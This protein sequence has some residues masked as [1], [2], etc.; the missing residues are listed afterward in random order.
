[1]KGYKN[2]QSYSV[3]IVDIKRLTDSP[4]IGFG[5]CAKISV[6]Q[7]KQ[8]IVKLTLDKL[9]L[10]PIALPY[11]FQH[12][13]YRTVLKLISIDLNRIMNDLG[14]QVQL[15]SQFSLEPVKSNFFT[16]ICI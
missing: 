5:E 9:K 6:E 12:S 7:E 1:M 13:I 16:L 4:E 8:R 2:Y 11:I 14:Q 15:L 10:F 3:P